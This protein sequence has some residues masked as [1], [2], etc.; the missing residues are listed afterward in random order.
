MANCSISKFLRMTLVGAVMFLAASS[1]FAQ[2]WQ[3]QRRIDTV[4]LKVQFRQGDRRID[5]NYMSNSMSLDHFTTI[6]QKYIYEMYGRVESV[7]IIGGASI[8]GTAALN[9]DLSNNRA[10][11]MVEILSQFVDVPSERVTV[12]SRGVNWEDVL[13][14]VKKD[15]LVPSK[16]KVID[17]LTN[18]PEETRK[19]ELE[20]LDGGRPYQYMY[21]SIYPYVRTGKMTVVLSGVPR[22]PAPA[23]PDTVIIVKEGVYNNITTMGGGCCD[24]VGKKKGHAMAGI[25]AG[26]RMSVLDRLDTL[27]RVP[28][29]AFRTNL[30]AP[31]LNVGFEVP[32]GNR[33]SMGADWYYPWVWRNPDHRNCFQLLG[34]TGEV[35]YWFGYRHQ[36]GKE[37]AKYRLLGHSLALIGGGG[38]YDFER[39]RDGFQGEFGLVGIDYMYAMPIGKRAGLHLEFDIALGYI[40]SKNKPYDVYTDGGILLHRDGIVSRFNWVGPVKAGVNLVVPI[41]EKSPEYRAAVAAQKAQKKAQKAEAKRIKEEEKAAAE[42]AAAV[43]VA[44][45][46]RQRAEAKAQA[47]AQKLAEQK[48]EAERKAAEL[49]AKEEARVAAEKAKAEAKAQAEAQKLAEQKAEAERK[50]AE[51]KAK[52]EAKAKAAEEKAAAQ[53]KAQEEKAKAEA[54]EKAR[55]EAEA[56]AKAE[57]KAQAEAQKLAAQKAEAERKAA[58]LKA[59]EEAKAKAAEEKAK[60]EAEKAAAQLKAQEEK[61]KAEAAEKARKEAEAKAKA[62]AKAHAEAQN[63]AEQKAEAE[64]KAAELKA[65]E[66]AK[67]QAEA[68]ALAEKR[69]KAEAQ[70]AERK[71]KAEA[72]AKADA[73]KA[74]AKAKADAEKAAAKAAREKAKAN[75]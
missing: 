36:E 39:Q 15:P 4:V 1:L 6:M 14:M 22:Y 18:S 65:K 70:A 61:A 74:A 72:K 73:E 19:A 8:E 9:R 42:A 32:I 69:A 55:K 51:L 64:R 33:I 37:F 57:A 68:K 12:D 38:Y 63:L 75:N 53:L 31:L 16:D 3:E 27:L 29:F 54:A 10:R 25:Y 41:F 71:A 20:R 35:R 46:N 49:K 67:A 21:K 43:V 26:R 2:N 59:K 23:S 66:E 34:G 28:V 48:A 47:E 58:E 44:N 7:N 45:D 60:L 52:E 30:L 13:D 17:I 50:A 24:P 11:R 5:K 62:E 56:K 40:G